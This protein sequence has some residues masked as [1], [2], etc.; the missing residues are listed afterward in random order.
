M[1]KISYQIHFIAFEI[2]YTY[3]ILVKQKMMKA[4][5]ENNYLLHTY[6]SEKIINR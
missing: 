6:L 3:S 2:Y 5:I 4:G 1:L